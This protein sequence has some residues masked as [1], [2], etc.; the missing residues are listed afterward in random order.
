[1]DLFRFL[2]FLSFDFFPRLI[3]LTWK[4][5]GP[6]QKLDNLWLYIL[7]PFKRIQTKDYTSLYTAYK[8]LLLVFA[9]LK[10]FFLISTLSLL[11]NKV[12]I[13]RSTTLLRSHSSEFPS[14]VCHG[15]HGTCKANVASRG[16]FHHQRR[17]HFNCHFGF[18]QI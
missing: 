18:L 9:Y 14:L 1:M 16:F 8:F 13:S 11:G 2:F 17:C 4:C 15:W 6:L 10:E 12:R 3:C 5:F 7:L